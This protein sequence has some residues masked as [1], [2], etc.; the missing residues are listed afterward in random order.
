MNELKY[1]S[2]FA[3]WRKAAAALWQDY[4]CHEFVQG[5]GDGSLPRKAF[6][7]YLIQDYVY[8]V[9]YSRAWALAVVKAEILEEMKTCSAIVNALVNDEMALHVKICA[10]E[11][12]DEAQLFNAI[13]ENETLAYTRYVLDAGL[14]GDFLDMMAALAPCAFGYGEIGLLLAKTS[15]PDNQ[16]QEWIDTYAGADYQ[17]LCQT[18]GKM[19]DQAVALRIGD[20]P[21]NSPRWQKLQNRFTTATQLETSFWSMGLRGT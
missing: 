2:S 8:L 21:Q 9:H 1:G 14:A 13:E 10:A 4:T 16:Y 11:G 17:N 12:I 19:I 6:I 15:A 5:L 18:I 20:Q 3:L 7:H